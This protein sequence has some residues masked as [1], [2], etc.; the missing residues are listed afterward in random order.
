MVQSVDMRFKA[1]GPA[2]GGAVKAPSSSRE[3]ADRLGERRQLHSGG[4]LGGQREE[5]GCP[6]KRVRVWE[7]RGGL[8]SQ[9]EQLQNIVAPILSTYQEAPSLYPFVPFEFHTV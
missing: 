3:D 4:L 2:G 9:G 6:A 7:T 1:E 8:S 5:G